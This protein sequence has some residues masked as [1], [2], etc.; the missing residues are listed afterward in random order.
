MGAHQ[1]FLISVGAMVCAFVAC[2]AS[3]DRPSEESHRELTTTSSAKETAPMDAAQVDATAKVSKATDAAPVIDVTSEA[4]ADDTKTFDELLASLREK[5]LGRA[6][7]VIDGRVKQESP[8]YDLSEDQAKAVAEYLLDDMP[9]MPH[10]RKLVDVLPRT[11]VELI[12]AV[13]ERDVDGGEAEKIADY[14]VRLTTT[15]TSP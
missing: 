4:L 8:K 11:T 10:S 13:H 9:R 12:R 15:P 2:T 1:G 3:E 7:S 6:A 5:G 14:L